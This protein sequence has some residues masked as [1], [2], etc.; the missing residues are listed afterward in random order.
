MIGDLLVIPINW[1]LSTLSHLKPQLVPQL[2]VFGDWIASNPNNDSLVWNRLISQHLLW[3]CPT[4]QS[5]I[6]LTDR[7]PFRA[8]CTAALVCSELITVNSAGWSHLRRLGCKK[9]HTIQ[10]N[11]NALKPNKTNASINA[12]DTMGSTTFCPKF[13]RGN[14]AASKRSFI[15]LNMDPP[16]C[17]W[18]FCHRVS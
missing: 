16:C 13:Q 7:N 4:V 3:I 10:P 6:L 11:R 1:Y 14:P 12:T 15:W 9:Y 18:G 8:A 17:S 5:T 2:K